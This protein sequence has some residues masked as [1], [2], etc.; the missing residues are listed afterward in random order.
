MYFFQKQTLIFFKYLLI[1]GLLMFFFEGNAQNCTPLDTMA[2]YEQTNE[3]PPALTRHPA[4]LAAFLTKDYVREDKKVLAISYWIVNNIQYNYRGFKKGVLLQKSSKEVLRNRKALC[5]EYAVL[6][7]EM[8]EAVDIPVAVVNGYTKGFDFFSTDTLYRAEHA[9]S[10]VRVEGTWHLMDLTYASGHTAPKKQHFAKMMVKLFKTSLAPKFKYVQ[11]FNP[12]WFYVSPDE[13]VFTHFPNLKRYQLLETPLSLQVYQQGGWSIH[14]HL[15]WYPKVLKESEEIDAFV[16]LSKLEQWLLEAKEGHLINPKNHRVKGFHYYWAVDSLYRAA[17]DYQSYSLIASKS[18]LKKME[19]YATIAEAA[20][21]QSI[22]DNNQEYENK[23]A[24]SWNWK[25]RLFDQNKK[26]V[27]ALQKRSQK[28]SKQESLVLEIAKNNLANQKFTAEQLPK[29]RSEST[30]NTEVDTYAV[31]AKF[32]ALLQQKLDSLEV[33]ASVAIDQKDSFLRSSGEGI[34]KILYPK[35]QL[36]LKI[37][38]GNSKAL[39]QIIDRKKMQLS[40][41]YE[42]AKILDKE[43]LTQSNQRADSINEVIVDTFLIAL[44]ENQIAAQKSIKNYCK[45]VRAELHLLKKEKQKIN[46]H[47]LLDKRSIAVLTDLEKQLVAY[48]AE[49]KNCLGFQQKLIRLLEN[50]IQYMESTM[51]TLLKDN[52]LEHYRHIQYMEYRQ[53][54]RQAENTKTHFVLQKIAKIKR[55][56]DL[57]QS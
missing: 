42:D 35:E 23:G 29:E 53:Q 20:L 11:K 38:K 26:H 48:K 10:M 55:L 7:K 40:L 22:C 52:R 31:Y 24:Q 15:S 1:G 6:F 3:V 46:K 8:C 33:L 5:R 32:S 56:I 14:G 36:V 43:W 13:F 37:H 39:K 19:Q 30:P 51:Q 41:I 21:Q 27:H 17:Y 16:S 34:Q 47:S 4:T 49:L 25:K 9:W 2:I 12:S 28:N 57:A 50:E 18:Y 44:H 54:I 45:I